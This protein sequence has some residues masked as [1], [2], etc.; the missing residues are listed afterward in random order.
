MTHGLLSNRPNSTEAVKMAEAL[1][2]PPQ[3][4]EDADA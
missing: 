1:F 2:Y 3:R 4:K